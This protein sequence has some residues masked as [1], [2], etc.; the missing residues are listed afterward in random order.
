[1]F[2]SKDQL[3][4]IGFKRIGNNVLISDKAS[5]YSPHLIEIGNDVRIDDFCI[6]SPGTS[7]VIGS[8][9]HIA[10]YASI[11]GK[12]EVIIEDFAGISGR[13]SVYSSND[14]YSGRFLTNP[15]VPSKYTN[16]TSGKV[17]LKKH[18]IVGNGSVILPNIT[19]E[20]GVAVGALSLVTKSFGPYVI[21]SGVPAKILKNRSEDL[22]NIEHEYRSVSL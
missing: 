9:V 6:L 11:I 21:I 16:V 15:T 12:G 8:N 17:H 13:V 14:D 1:M 5:I 2:L 4:A 20:E 18:V 10:C 22:K 3:D 7:L 19:L